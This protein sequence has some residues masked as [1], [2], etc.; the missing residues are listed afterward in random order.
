MT[1]QTEPRAEQQ[2]K[3]FIRRR[4][5]IVDEPFQYRLIGVLLTIWGANSLFFSIVLYFFYQGHIQRFYDLVPRP[6]VLPWVSASVLFAAALGFVA[7][8]GAVVVTVIGIYLTNQVAGPLHR[9]KRSMNRVAEGDV[10][11]EIRFRQRDFLGDLPGYFNNM[12][13]QLREQAAS[14]AN[15][16]RA[17]EDHLPSEPNR[18]LALLR[19][20]REKKEGQL[21]FTP[22]RC[23]I[24]KQ[25]SL[26]V[27]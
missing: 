27:H 8:F 9:I 25:A 11:F 14:D 13:R 18:A 1:T 19:Q 26:S 15:R 20:L 7:L 24:D 5:F 17:I 2:G 22:D 3:T 4:R 23:S 21:G 16:L 10:S 12:L 6:G